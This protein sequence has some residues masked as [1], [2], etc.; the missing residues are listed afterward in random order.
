[1]AD[2][3]IS[4]LPKLLGT[5]LEANDDLA[6]ADYSA[7]ETRRLT[8]KDLV[9]NGVQ[10]IDNGVIPGAKIVTDSITALQI[11]PDAVTD[12]ELADDAVDTAAIKDL[13][14]VNGK[15]ALATL[16]GDRIVAVSYTH[17]TLPTKRIV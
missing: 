3:R 2:L 7:S 4:E 16:T 1:M 10:L 8:T 6:V 11:A 17:L 9:Q 14:V 5:D 13:A 12:S 15:V